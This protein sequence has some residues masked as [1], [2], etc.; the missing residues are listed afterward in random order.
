MSFS[1][2]L[3]LLLNY[4]VFI[5]LKNKETELHIGLTSLHL[6]PLDRFAQEKMSINMSI[7]QEYDL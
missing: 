7:R 3:Q 5:E 4:G 2:L 6:P 1:E